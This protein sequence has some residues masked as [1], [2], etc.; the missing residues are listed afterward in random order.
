MPDLLDTDTD[1]EDALDRSPHG[2]YSSDVEAL[3]SA[4]GI[5]EGRMKDALQATKG[6][7]I[8]DFGA[9]DASPVEISSKA[10]PRLVQQ[11]DSQTE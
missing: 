9:G 2:G 11:I 8:A 10:L 3:S 7:E 4:F 6:A 5:G 1:L